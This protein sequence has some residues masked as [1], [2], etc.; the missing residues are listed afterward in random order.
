MDVIK[1]TRRHQTPTGKNAQRGC[2]QEYRQGIKKQ[3]L[4]RDESGKMPLRGKRAVRRNTA[5]RESLN[6]QNP[7]I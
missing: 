5:I 7:N 2:T 1:K 6:Q 3:R 4:L